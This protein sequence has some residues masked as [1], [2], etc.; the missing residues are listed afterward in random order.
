M[1]TNAKKN[2]I[3]CAFEDVAKCYQL[4]NLGKE[5]S[6]FFNILWLF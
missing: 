6:S 4:M 3:K 2:K 5:Y 1:Y